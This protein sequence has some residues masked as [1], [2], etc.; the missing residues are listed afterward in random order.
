MSVKMVKPILVRGPTLTP[1]VILPFIVGQTLGTVRSDASNNVGFTFTPN[2]NLTVTALGRWIISGNSRTHNL[3]I[4]QSGSGAT[5]ASASVNTTL[6]TPGSYLYAS[7]TPVVLTSGVQYFCISD[8]RLGDQWY[9]SDTTVT[10]GPD[11]AVNGSSFNI[12]LWVAG[13]IS[14]VPTNFLYHL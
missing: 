1:P 12:S 4:I 3:F 8:E 6:G 13:S 2:K 5:I 11:G 9:S 10:A 7:I 14:Y